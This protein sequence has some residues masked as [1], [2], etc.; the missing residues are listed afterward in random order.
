M[1]PHLPV[2]P[3]SRAVRQ[4]ENAS[5]GTGAVGSGEAGAQHRS[6]TAG[7]FP[8]QRSGGL[9]GIYA[10]YYTDTS[11]LAGFCATSKRDTRHSPRWLF[12]DALVVPPYRNVP[13]IHV[14]RPPVTRPR[15]GH[16]QRGWGA[17]DCEGGAHPDTNTRLCFMTQK[18]M[19]SPKCTFFFLCHSE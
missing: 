17:R 19:K 1:P 2:T 12:W 4:G 15:A 10:G 9:L 6:G 14:V 5:G 3:C 16:T 18:I 8:G 13:G 11:P 7:A